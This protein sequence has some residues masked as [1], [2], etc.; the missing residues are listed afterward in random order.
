[1]GLR[2]SLR[3]FLYW[4]CHVNAGGTFASANDPHDPARHPITFRMYPQ[5]LLRQQAKTWRVGD[6]A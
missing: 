3:L 4:P 2:P 6:R 1:M 5:A